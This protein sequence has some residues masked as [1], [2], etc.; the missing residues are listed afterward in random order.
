M[1]TIP[2]GRIFALSLGAYST[3]AFAS[4]AN[5]RNPALA[6]RVCCS[7]ALVG[8]SLGGVTAGL[9][10]LRGGTVAWSIPSGIPLFAYSFSYDTLAAFFNLILA[11]LVSATAI[12]SFGY[13][14]E[15]EGK[16]N[17]G[18]FGFLFNILLLSLVIV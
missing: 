13:L 1:S 6:R 12:Y 3:G 5:W 18:A 9:S 2:L 14:K 17:I 15:F 16:R 10:I 4:L 7:M 11:I 8:A